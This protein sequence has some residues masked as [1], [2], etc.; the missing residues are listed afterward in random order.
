MPSPSSILLGVQALPPALFGAFI[1]YDPTK[2]GFDNVP[3]A[4]AHVVGFSSLGIS[5]ANIFA[6]MQGRRARH[7]FMLMS[8]PMRLAAAWVFWLDGEQVR[9]GMIWDFVNAWL[10]LGIVAWEWR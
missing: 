6:M 5:A 8:F 2:I 1:L 9:G 7:Q 10:N 3:V 4:L